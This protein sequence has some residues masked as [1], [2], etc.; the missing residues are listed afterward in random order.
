[1]EDIE[2]GDKKKFSQV[3][4]SMVRDLL[5]ACEGDQD[6]NYS[7]ELS[8]LSK[9]YKR[10]C[11][12]FELLAAYEHLGIS[13]PKLKKLLM[14]KSVRSS[15]GIIQISVV[16]PP[17]NFSCKYD[18]AMCPSQPGMPR[19]YVSNEDAVARAAQ[20][21]FDALKQMH[22][23]MRS[24]QDN[25][26]PVEKGKLEI[27]ILGGTFSSYDHTLATTFI[28]DLYY[29]ANVYGSSPAREKKTL[30]EEIAANSTQEAGAYIIGMGVETR[31]DEICVDEIVRFRSYGVTRVELGVQHTNDNVLK[32]VNRGHK[33]EAS[34]RA[35]TLLK[36]YGFKV[37]IHIMTD[38]PGSSPELDIECYEKVLRS[39]PFLTPD[40]LKD[41]PCLNMPYTKLGSMIDDGSWRPYAELEDGKM[42][43]DVLVKR[44]ELTPEWVRVDRI[45]RD[46]HEAS[47][48]DPNG[49]SSSTHKTNLGQLVTIEAEKR[50][51]FCKC[52]RCREIRNDKFEYSDI[53]FTKTKVP[54]TP[55]AFEYFIQATVNQSL[56]GFI[57]VR[58]NP[59][60]K[61][62]A[63]PVLCGNVAIIRELHV[64]GA[65]SSVGKKDSNVQHYGIGKTLLGMAE[66][67]SIE[68]NCE[69]IAV[70][71]GVGVR[72]YYAKNGYKLMDTYMT[73]L[74]TRRL[75]EKDIM[76]YVYIFVV[77]FVMFLSI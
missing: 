22:S 24:L 6:V 12:K 15:S 42:L 76:V 1:M 69:K 48:E 52:I 68:H 55:G 64:Y 28:R 20:N 57:R 43:M 11:T 37:E 32:M 14:V 38:L 36:E 35:I 63:F 29:A 34:R 72:E 49:Y 23:R 19:S 8:K 18:C 31:P 59:Q 44:Q 16:M 2:G 56:L 54:A 5:K 74:L 4:I 26:H 53:K 27:R 17:D 41:Y 10:M 46:F 62:K 13:S 51:V 30:E 25:G 45:Q 50:G 60:A 7:K 39:D 9:K 70:I 21:D 77:L 58:I 66:D 73:K 47:D 71:S 3:A 33:V 40:Y 67:I 75:N 61:R 65:A